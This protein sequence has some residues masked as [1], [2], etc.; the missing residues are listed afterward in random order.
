MRLSATAFSNIR[1]LESD[2][3][4][5]EKIERQQ[6]NI[7]KVAKTDRIVSLQFESIEFDG[8]ITARFRIVWNKAFDDSYV[9]LRINSDGNVI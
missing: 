3:K 4:F 6:I 2:P 1:K 7:G 9:D 5:I 8:I